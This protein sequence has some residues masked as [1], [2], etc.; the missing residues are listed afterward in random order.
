M[1]SPISEQRFHPPMI[2]VAEEILA[3]FAQRATQLRHRMDVVKQGYC[4]AWQ[5][6][7]DARLE[8]PAF[9]IDDTGFAD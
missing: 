5:P 6:L 8:E 2:A 4:P 3:L 1:K 9:R 7:G